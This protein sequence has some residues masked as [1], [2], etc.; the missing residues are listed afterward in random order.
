[1]A[2]VP[3]PHTKADS[4]YHFLWFN[5]VSTIGAQRNFQVCGMKPKASSPAICS[6]VTPAWARKYAT[7]T[8]IY[9]VIIP[10]GRMRIMNAAGC[11]LVGRILVVSAAIMRTS[12][13]LNSFLNGHHSG[14]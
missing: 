10:H 2:K 3:T 1:M 11:E 12:S 9:P 7:A 6:V 5:V 14:A 13:G 4:T 8:P